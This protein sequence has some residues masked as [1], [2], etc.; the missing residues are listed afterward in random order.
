MQIYVIFS[1]SSITACGGV[2]PQS[3]R[4]GVPILTNSTHTAEANSEAS[5]PAAA[6]TAA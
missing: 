4:G 6:S 5:L 3:S 1:M 2:P